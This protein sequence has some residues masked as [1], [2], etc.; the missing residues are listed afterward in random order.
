MAGILSGWLEQESNQALR[1]DRAQTETCLAW[2]RGVDD[3]QALL[4]DD[5]DICDS[6][7][8]DNDSMRLEKN[9]LEI[10]S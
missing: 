8:I 2:G 3:R 10:W 5:L 6:K 9:E 1:Q 7:S 4:M